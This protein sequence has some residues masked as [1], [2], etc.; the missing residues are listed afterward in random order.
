MRALLSLGAD[1]AC[2]GGDG[3]RA[4]DH[5]AAA[6]RWHI[7]ALLDPDYPLPSTLGSDGAPRQEAH[8]DHLLDALRFGHWNVAEEFVG[9]IDQ[10]PAAALADLLLDLSEQGLSAP[11]DWLANHGLDPAA[12][13]SSG[14]TLVDALVERLPASLDALRELLSRGA[15][16]GGA[17]LVARVL[18]KARDDASA[19]ALRVLAVDLLGRG[20]DWCGGADRRR[21]T[22]HMAVALGD[23]ALSREL[24]RRGADPDARDAQGRTPLHLAVI[25]DG[26]DAQRL[27]QALVAAELSGRG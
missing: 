14:E 25:H 12:R 24:L 7:V 5:A 4:L 22:L 13:T 6:G 3:K 23:V 8:A 16:V 21:S 26:P 18:A 15:P 27:L 20:A 10:W 2:V 1:R 9:V 17:G 19:E 11:R